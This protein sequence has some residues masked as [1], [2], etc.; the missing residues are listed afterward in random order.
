MKETISCEEA[1]KSLF[2]YLDHELEENEHQA[3]DAHL[4]ECRSCFSR[5]EFER[6]LKEKLGQSGK[7]QAPAELK[8]RVRKILQE[9]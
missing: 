1:L 5:A 7:E 8:Q 3:M 9:F 4:H 2:Q 6:R